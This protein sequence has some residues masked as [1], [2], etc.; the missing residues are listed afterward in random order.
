[1]SGC[2]SVNAYDRREPGW[3]HPTCSSVQFGLCGFQAR[4]QPS[5]EV[6]S[7]PGLAH[8]ACSERDGWLCV[9]L[10]PS[11]ESSFPS[12]VCLHL[13]G[14]ERLHILL[15]ITQGPQLW[16]MRGWGGTGLSESICPGLLPQEGLSGVSREIAGNA[17]LFTSCVNLATS[18]HLLVIQISSFTAQHP[19]PTLFSLTAIA[20]C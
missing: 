7:D 15:R 17:L 4:S 20:P 2:L 19:G 10:Y 8:F 9:H 5:P 13:I 6:G 18:P 14:P 11:P 12:I 1:M 3:W 16:L